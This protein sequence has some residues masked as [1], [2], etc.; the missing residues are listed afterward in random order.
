VTLYVWDHPDEFSIATLPAPQ[1]IS[2]PD[3]KL[4]VDT[5]TDLNRLR[6]LDCIRDIKCSAEMIVQCYKA[7]YM[8]EKV[9]KFS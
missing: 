9:E 3:I 8:R 1:E 6:N 7:V 2:F 4:D 5:E